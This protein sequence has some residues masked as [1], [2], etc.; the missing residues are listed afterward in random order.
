MRFLACSQDT[1]LTW[2]C[3]VLCWLL[4]AIQP[5]FRSVWRQL[6]SAHGVD[7]GYGF[8][9]INTGEVMPFIHSFNTMMASAPPP[10]ADHEGLLPITLDFE[11]LYTNIPLADLQYRLKA[12]IAHVFGLHRAVGVQFT[13]V[14]KSTP[15]WLHAGDAALAVS[16]RGLWRRGA[17]DGESAPRTCVLVL[18]D[19]ATLL[20]CVLSNT[21]FSFGGR[22]FHQVKGIPMG[23]QPAPL[24]ANLFLAAYEFEFFQ[25]LLAAAPGPGSRPP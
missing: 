19:I 14:K 24:I 12:V 13:S 7:I 6:G 21:F 11:R 10:L 3:E 2:A 15:V 5:E 20:D 1:P 23:I 17:G 22:V 18:S 4:S 16:K 25:R 8:T 9:V